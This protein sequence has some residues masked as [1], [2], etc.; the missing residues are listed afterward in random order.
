MAPAAPLSFNAGDERPAGVLPSNV[1]YD[2]SDLFDEAKGVAGG[3][4]L[5]RVLVAHPFR[6]VGEDVAFMLE[7]F[8]HA[9]IAVHPPWPSGKKREWAVPAVALKALIFA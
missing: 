5:L 8:S 3:D 9:V 2:I 4:A 6:K 1:A 7:H